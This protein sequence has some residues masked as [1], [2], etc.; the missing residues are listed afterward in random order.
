M[1]KGHHMSYQYSTVN[2]KQGRNNGN[3][4]NKSDY[5]RLPQYLSYMNE[6]M[7]EQKNECYLGQFPHL[8]GYGNHLTTMTP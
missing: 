4:R 2:M 8:Q 3:K 5:T 1:N 6:I 7:E